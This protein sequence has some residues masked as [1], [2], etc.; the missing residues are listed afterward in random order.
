MRTK[1][2]LLTA[3]L[4]V[5]GIASS[6]AQVFSV[7]A[8]GYVNVVVPAN[9]SMI[10]NPLDTSANTL[11]NLIPNPPNFSNF[12]KFNGTGFD[13]A[14]FAFG[15]WDLP[16]LTLNPGEGGFL[17]TSASFTNTFVGTVMQGTLA[18]PIPAG[19]SIRSSQVPQGGA[20]DTVLGLTTLSTF[21]NVYKW[22]VTAQSYDIYTVLPGGGWSGPNGGTT[23]PSLNVAEPVFINAGAA[24]SWNRTFSVNN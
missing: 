15:S 2:L 1:T 7:N 24:T 16:N 5:A 3:V 22:N 23:A 17:N 8:V 14:T 13:I 11:G 20:I 18:N 10:A 21:D 6:S 4:G 9:L 12:Y 19:L